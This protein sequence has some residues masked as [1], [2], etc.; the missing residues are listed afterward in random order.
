MR[1][2]SATS[3]KELD[4]L[5]KENPI[6]EKA[7][8]KLLYVSADE[9]LRYELDMREKAELDYWSAMKTSF[10]EGKEEGIQVGLTAAA[11]K[12]LKRNRPIDEII[13]DTGLTREEVEGLR[14]TE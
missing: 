13:E 14:G 1:F 9:Q 6:F 2:L 4:M 3:E 5:A 10:K 11:K 8:N 12:M 7:I